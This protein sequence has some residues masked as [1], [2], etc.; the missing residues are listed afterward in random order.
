MLHA[1]IHNRELKLRR[2]DKSH[3]LIGRKAHRE[4]GEVPGMSARA[5]R[6]SSL[7]QDSSTSPG[8][9]LAQEIVAPAGACH[10][11]I[12]SLPCST[13]WGRWWIRRGSFPLSHFH[14]GPSSCAT[15][16]ACCTAIFFLAGAA[17]DS[18]QAACSL[19]ALNAATKVVHSPAGR[20][21]QWGPP[22]TRLEASSWDSSAS[23]SGNA[24][25]L[26]TQDGDASESPELAGS[27]SDDAPRLDLLRGRPAARTHTSHFPT[28]C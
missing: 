25:A 22:R 2:S 4:A 12:S 10:A 8:C 11:M 15:I 13:A 14:L 17:A 21:L 16:P 1:G 3:L 23:S 26:S 7:A 24:A 27:S 5:V 6:A 20:G 19:P 18:V 9:T 28:C